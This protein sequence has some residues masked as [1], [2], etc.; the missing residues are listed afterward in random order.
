MTNIT[1]KNLDTTEVV[2]PLKD[3]IYGVIEADERIAVLEAQLEPL[4]EAKKELK[5]KIAEEFKRRGEFTTRIEGATATLS[6]RKTAQ[7]I[8]EQL[9]ISQ[10][11][12]GGL[13]DIYVV[14]TLSPEF[15]GLKKKMTSVKDKAE[16]LD[17]MEIK[18]TEYVSIRKNDKEDARKVVTGDFV[19]KLK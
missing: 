5:S 13:A 16:L 10:L 1:I 12:K 14:E 15:D 11:K 6:V 2:T 18:E 3:L 17:G 9:V 8:D 4:K 7:V 19:K